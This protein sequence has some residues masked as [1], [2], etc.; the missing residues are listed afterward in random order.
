[1]RSLIRGRAVVAGLVSVACLA[2]FLSLTDQTDE[3]LPR[4]DLSTSEAPLVSDVA[5]EILTDL[6]QAGPVPDPPPVD[7]SV[8]DVVHL[9]GEPM[10]LAPIPDPPPVEPPT[11]RERELR[12]AAEAERSADQLMAIRREVNL[13]LKQDAFM[14]AFD[15]A[16][17]SRAFR[18]KVNK[19]A[20]ERLAEQRRL[21][22]EHLEKSE[23]DRRTLEALRKQTVADEPKGNP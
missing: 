7:V 18:K 14:E 13:S 23:A 17:K 16:T 2:S 12:A 19:I 21:L 4:P 11:R 3:F 10:S 1:V 5:S 20:A 15:T 9:L 22:E 8:G 6:A